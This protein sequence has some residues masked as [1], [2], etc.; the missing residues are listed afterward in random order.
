ME[1]RINN[2]PIP[3]GKIVKKIGLKDA[4]KV[5]RMEGQRVLLPEELLMNPDYVDWRGRRGWKIH[6]TCRQCKKGFTVIKGC[7]REHVQLCQLCTDLRK[8]G[9]K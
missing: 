8:K 5:C 7:K 4:L 3:P 9:R 1:M 6:R 2:E